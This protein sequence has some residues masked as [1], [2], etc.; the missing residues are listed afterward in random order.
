ML[1]SSFAAYE[2]FE[3]LLATWFW[4]SGV[5]FL[6]AG[7]TVP[8]TLDTNRADLISV[9]VADYLSIGGSTKVTILVQVGCRPVCPD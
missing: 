7:V 6:E 4:F 3:L 1:K 8:I 9:K 5:P 2:F